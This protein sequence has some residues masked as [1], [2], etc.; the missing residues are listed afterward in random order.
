MIPRRY[1]QDAHLLRPPSTATIWPCRCQ[2]CRRKIGCSVER[3]RSFG[4]TAAC[5]LE[6]G[7]DHGQRMRSAGGPYAVQK[8]GHFRP[9]RGPTGVH[10]TRRAP[11]P[12]VT[13]TDMPA[14][15]VR[16]QFAAERSRPETRTAS[17]PH[18]FTRPWFT[19]ISGALA[20]T[21]GFAVVF[22]LTGPAQVP[23]GVAILANATVS[24]A[25]GL[26]AAVQ[27]AGL[28][29]T[30]DVKGAIE[31][32]KRIDNGRVT[33]KGWA[34]DKTGSGSPLTIIA[35][36]EGPH[37]L[38]TVTKGA[39]KD[40]AQMFGLSD[41]GARNASFEAAF[42]CGA[43]QNLIVVAVTADRTYSQF[44]SIACP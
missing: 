2:N 28:R 6:L 35:F 19:W 24:D 41:A 21:L 29:G 8:T 39:R 3:R 37:V 17:R 18:V 14:A 9:E 4:C 32:L 40:V 43:G 12:A 22:W 44:R 31:E 30:P 5:Q 33:I 25:T 36:A 11:S 15:N 38:T 42:S 7:T 23:P 34:V 10:P 26:M 1:S 16:S 13:G 20:A 27:T